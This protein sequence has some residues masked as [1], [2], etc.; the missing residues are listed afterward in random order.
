MDHKSKK[1][2]FEANLPKPQ[3]TFLDGKQET[4]Y[5]KTVYLRLPVDR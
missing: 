4:T 2:N 3:I 1:D 5:V